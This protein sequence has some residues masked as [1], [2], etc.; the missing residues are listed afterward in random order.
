MM[1]ED[2]KVSLVGYIVG[3]EVRR[4]RGILYMSDKEAERNG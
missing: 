3:D 4:Q 2:G 1:E